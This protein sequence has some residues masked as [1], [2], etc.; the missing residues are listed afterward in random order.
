MLLRGCQVGSRLKPAHKK[1]LIPARH[2]SIDHNAIINTFTYTFEGL[3]EASGLP[4]WALIPITTFALR[5][6][7]TLPLAIIQRKRIQ[8]QSTLK[9]IVSALNPILKMNLAKRVQKA[10]GLQ[11]LPDTDE[12]VKAAQAPLANMS[13][14]QIL[15]L[16]TKETRK[17]QKE[18]FKKHNVQIWKNFILPTFQIPLWIMM[19]LTMRDL[20]GWSSW[21]NLHNKALDPSLY[22]EGCLWFQDLAVADPMHVFPLIL[23]VIS[24]CNVEWTFRTLELSRL[25]QRLKYRPNLTDAVANFSRMSIVFM[26]AIS[27]HAPAA[28]VLYWISSQFFSLIQNIVLDIKYPISFTPK[29]RFGGDILE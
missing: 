21:D 26:M 1:L 13:Y 23:G 20:S 28:L 4:W 16:T 29:K 19:S 9:P 8:K 10:K 2:Y 14:E 12:S 3:H 27:I 24:L 17:R 6:V 15:L 7:W 25:T 5:S 22:V 11:Q 18:L